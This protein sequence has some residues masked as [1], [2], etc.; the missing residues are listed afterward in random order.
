[1]ELT[2]AER[3]A[4]DSL[5]FD[6]RRGDIDCANCAGHDGELRPSGESGARD[7][8]CKHIGTCLKVFVLRWG[9]EETSHCPVNC[10]R[11]ERATAKQ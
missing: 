1:M 6:S 2:D 10:T 5:R 7:E 11:R 8:L 4:I 3:A 9:A